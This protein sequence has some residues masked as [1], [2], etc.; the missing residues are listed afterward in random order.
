MRAP[1][2]SEG[3]STIV[4]NAAFFFAMLSIYHSRSH[5]YGEAARND[6]AGAPGKCGHPSEARA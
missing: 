3:V 2:R 4:R 5:E 6:G 1:E